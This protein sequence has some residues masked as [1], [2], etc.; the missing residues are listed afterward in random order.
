[1]KPVLA[2]FN[3]SS[4]WAGGLLMAM[5]LSGLLVS[6]VSYESRRLHNEL[7][8]VLENKN[9]A[10][11][12]WGRLLLEHSTLTS[13]ARVERLAREELDMIVPRPSNIE[14]VMQ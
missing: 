11:V 1:M 5:I 13:P 4:I 12:G 10:Q 14:M 7:Q 8:K 9:K 3:Q 6:Y 2:V